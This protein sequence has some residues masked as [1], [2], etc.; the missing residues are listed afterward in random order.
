M[1]VGFTDKEEEVMLGEGYT[2]EQSEFGNVYYPKEGIVVSDTVQ[3][4]YVVYPWITCFE[5]DGIEIIKNIN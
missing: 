4:K 3:I 1:S 2:F 5:V